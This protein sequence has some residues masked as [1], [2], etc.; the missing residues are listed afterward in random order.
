MLNESKRR[1]QKNLIRIDFHLSLIFFQSNWDKM[2]VAQ[3]Q[4]HTHIKQR[5]NFVVLFLKINKI[6]NSMKIN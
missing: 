5:W 1:E 4:T 2:S 3:H 6:Y